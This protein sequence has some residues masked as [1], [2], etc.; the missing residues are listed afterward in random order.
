MVAAGRSSN[1]VN[2][3]D[4]LPLLKAALSAAGLEDHETSR[5]VRR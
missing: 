5:T 2:G 4:G 3:A 1:S